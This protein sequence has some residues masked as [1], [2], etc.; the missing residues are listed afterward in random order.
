MILSISGMRSS[1]FCASTSQPSSSSHS[2][3][4][5]P[6]HVAFRERRRQLRAQDN[7]N[8]SFEAKDLAKKLG[9]KTR[10]EVLD[11]VLGSRVMTDAFVDFCERSFCVENILFVL[12]VQ[13]FR[14]LETS[15]KPA[16]AKVIV[17]HYF[18]EESPLL[19]NIDDKTMM[20]VKE[21]CERGKKEGLP[22]NDIFDLAYLQVFEQ[23]LRDPFQ[24]WTALS[25][26]EE[27]LFEMVKQNS[28]IHSGAK[29]NDSTHT[30]AAH[31]RDSKESSSHP[32]SQTGHE[33]LRSTNSD[34]TTH[35]TTRLSKV[36]SPLH[37]HGFVHVSSFKE[38]HSSGSFHDEGP[39]VGQ[40]ALAR[41]GKTSG[42]FHGNSRM[43]HATEEEIEM[44][45]VAKS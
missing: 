39:V 25:E 19:I 41:E 13:K 45:R 22:S 14:D 4:V 23:L 26:F 15:E 29:S 44:E 37:E 31:Y 7:T 33:H 43:A 38:Q 17:E 28:S 35:Q 21:A 5:H 2:G 3:M 27:A 42:S 1:C 20:G 40:R 10:K 8:L 6:V 34:L 32:N 30:S 11:L 24:R 12:D 18:L 36:S 9:S 16:A